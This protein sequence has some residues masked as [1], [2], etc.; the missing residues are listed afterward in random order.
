M[1]FGVEANKRTIHTID[2]SNI[3]RLDTFPEGTLCRYRTIAD[4]AEQK[5][6]ILHYREDGA[7]KLAAEALERL[8]NKPEAKV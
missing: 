3:G 7:I 4:G 8:A 2:I 6:A 5:F 1:P